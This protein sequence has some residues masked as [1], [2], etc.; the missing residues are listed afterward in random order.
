VTR[1]PA[2]LLGLLISAVLAACT[3]PTSPV[4]SSAAALEPTTTPSVQGTPS[5]TAPQE[6][7][8]STLASP[9]LAP[10]PTLTPKASAPP[11][12]QTLAGQ[13]LVVRMSGLVPDAAILA[14][15]RAGQIGGVVLFGANISDAAQVRTLTRTLQAAAAAGGQPKLLISTDQEGG[16]IRRVPWIPPTLSPPQIG[17]MASTSVAREQGRLTGIALADLGINVDLAPV[18][19]LP[20]S[21]ASIL[22]QQG[23]TF[24]F[25]AD[26]NASLVDAFA[27]GLAAGGVVPVLKHFP[28]LG[29][30]QHDTDSVVVTLNLTRT[31]LA[32]GLRPY[33]RVAGLHMVL[34]SNAVYTVFDPANAA[35]WS[36]AVAGDMLRRDNGFTGVSMTDS[37]TGA[38]AARGVSESSLAVSAATA[39]TDFILVLDKDEA[40]ALAAC[41]ALLAAAEGGAVPVATLRASYDRIVR[42]KAGLAGA[43]Q[44]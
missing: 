35:G 6:P 44:G 25:E 40:A 13:K 1:R 11:S 33:Q 21:T 43:P 7:P 15:V 29:Y 19:D 17:E 36:P 28:G 16:S 22:Y 9:S 2:G 8:P 27:A 42:L 3:A 39:G 26:L 37:L 14:R 5:P 12:A 41:D 30:A 38:A 32:P 18:A 23:R 20:F 10:G 34:L 4:P 24:S 31:G